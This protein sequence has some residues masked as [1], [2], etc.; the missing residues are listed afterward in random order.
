MHWPGLLGLIW[1]IYVPG[2]VV[3]VA[4]MG[5][6]RPQWLGIG[7]AALIAVLS[8][9]ALMF[10]LNLRAGRSMVGVVLHGLECVG[11]RSTPHARD[12]L[13]PPVVVGFGESWEQAGR[14]GLRACL[15][16]F[17]Q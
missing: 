17:A 7:A 9:F 5:M 14:G 10:A 3:L 4:G 8:I 6:A 11:R 2:V 1:W 13:R 12:D 16:A 15:D